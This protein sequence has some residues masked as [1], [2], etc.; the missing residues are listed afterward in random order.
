[1]RRSFVYMLTTKDNTALYTGVT[2]DLARRIAQHQARQG[3]RFTA[4]YNV[5]K[6]V[7]F[8]EFGDIRDAIAREKQ[9]KAGSR[10]KKIDLI[11]IT[12]PDWRDLAEDLR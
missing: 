2:S 6:L 7:Y 1:M 5:T 10:Q 8:E 4:K 3:S 11:N 9:I 12:N